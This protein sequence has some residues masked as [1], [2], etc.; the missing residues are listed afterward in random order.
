MFGRAYSWDSLPQSTCFRCE[1]AEDVRRLDERYRGRVR[2]PA[3]KLPVPKPPA[4]KP[5]SV[6]RKKEP[7]ST[8]VQFVPP[9]ESAGRFKARQI[10][11]EV[12]FKH[13]I[14]V[15]DML[16]VT[17]KYKI[18]R[19]RQEAAYRMKVELEMSYPQIAMRVGVQ[20]HTTVLH[21]ACM[22][23]VRNK[24]P[25]PPGKPHRRFKELAGA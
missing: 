10:L 18:V 25:F 23:A 11:C 9:P 20:D 5:V 19:A 4:P 2:V 16:A 14:L 21:G 13:G 12:A 6:K 1:T 17:R 24:L 8:V 7:E 15:K 3:I 22:H